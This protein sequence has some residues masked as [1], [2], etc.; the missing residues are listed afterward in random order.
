MIS[1][2]VEMK[3]WGEVDNAENGKRRYEEELGKRIE[4]RFT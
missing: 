4:D 2:L 1:H 3:L